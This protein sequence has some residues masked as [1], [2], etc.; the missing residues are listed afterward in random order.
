MRRDIIGQ[1]VPAQLAPANPAVNV[2]NGRGP[3][4]DRVDGE[5]GQAPDPLQVSADCAKLFATRHICKL[6]TFLHMLR[7][8]HSVTLNGCHI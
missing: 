5:A 6:N 2:A 4:N 8:E 1:N 7:S 3:P